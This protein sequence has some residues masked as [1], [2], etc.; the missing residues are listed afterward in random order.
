[1]QKNLSVWQLAGLTFTAVL[2][3]LLHFL[4]SWTDLLLFAPIAAV[5]EST[6][7][8]MKI[9]FFPMLIFAVIQ[10]RFYKES[11]F[12]Q[13]KTVGIILGTLLIPFLFYFYNGAFGKSPDWINILIFFLAAGVAYSVEYVLFQRDVFNGKSPV[14]PI[15]ILS[16]I[17]IAFIAFTFFQPPLPIFQDPITKLYGI[18]CSLF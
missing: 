12:W 17:A 10:S 3:T 7:E 6:F 9:L 1:M 5:N 2:G 14:F 16:V 11:G 13:V 8:H 18:V 4:F 15:V